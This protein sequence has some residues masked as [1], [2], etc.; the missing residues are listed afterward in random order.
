MELLSDI[1][2]HPVRKRALI[3]LAALSLI[4]VLSDFFYAESGI[5]L[6][7][8]FVYFTFSILYCFWSVYL[9]V[10]IRG[11]MKTKRSSNVVIEIGVWG[12]VWRS[13]LL[14]FVS[15]MATVI[16]LRVLLGV[17]FDK[18]LFAEAVI[19]SVLV[20]AFMPAFC[21]LF[22]SSNRKQQL[23]AG[24]KYFRGY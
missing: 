2:L 23:Y 8:L 18:T 13:W 22:Y 19:F 16:A 17:H 9:I 10:K 7:L 11:V 4:S 1:F 20:M 15:S 24:L 14:S 3:I 12:Y 21:W 5:S 6:F